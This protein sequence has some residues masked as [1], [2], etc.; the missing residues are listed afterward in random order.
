MSRDWI[1][2]G[3]LNSNVG[4]LSYASRYLEVDNGK[5]TDLARLWS[6]F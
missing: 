3:R 4:I 6:F 2:E 1:N 5:F